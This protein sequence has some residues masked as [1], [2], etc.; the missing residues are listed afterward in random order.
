MARKLVVHGDLRWSFWLRATLMAGAC[1]LAVLTLGVPEALARGV[2]D[3]TTPAAYTD[4]SGLGITP[5][6]DVAQTF[7]AGRTGF[8]D[9]VA[10]ALSGGDDGRY[11]IQ[12]VP[13]DASGVPAGAPLASRTI[14]ACHIPQTSP[15]EIPFG[16]A[17]SITAGTRYA[18]VAA[19]EPGSISPTNP[20]PPGISWVG[21]S[22]YANGAA[23]SGLLS[24]TP[25]WATTEFGDVGFSTYVSTTAP[26]ALDRDGTQTTVTSATNPAAPGAV[27]FTASVSDPSHPARVPTG[28]VAFRIDNHDFPVIQPLDAQ[29][30]ASQTIDS[31]PTGTSTITAAY[32]PDTDGFGS[33]S[34]AVDE[35]IVQDSTQTNVVAEPQAIRVGETTTL[36]AT[37]KDS[38]APGKTPTGTVQFSDD[39]NQPIGGPV[40]LQSGSA[41]V[42]TPALSAGTHGFSATYSASDTSFVPSSGSVQVPVNH[43]PSATAVSVQ[44]PQLVAGQPATFDAAVNGTSS[45]GHHP[46]GDVQFVIGSTPIGPRRSLDGAGHASLVAAGP[47]GSYQLHANYG[48]DNYFAAGEGAVPLTVG[49]A[50]TTTTMTSTPNPVGI[51]GE[52]TIDVDVGVVPPGD[53]GLDGPLQFFVDGQPDGPPIDLTGFTGVTVTADAGDI[54]GDATITARYLG[55]GNT[56][57]S[58]A[59][60]VQ[61]VRGAAAQASGGGGSGSPTSGPGS[62]SAPTTGPNATEVGAALAAVSNALRKAV[63]ARGLRA[64][65]GLTETFAAPAAGRLVQQV[66]SPTAPKGATQARAA[67]KLLA[68]G[69]A[70]FA[71]A[72][73]GK[74]KLKLTAAGR[75]A[76]RRNDTIKL[77]VV[78][79]FIPA[80][81]P[82]TQRQDHFS[83]R[84]ATRPRRTAA[85]LVIPRW[86]WRPAAWAW[87]APNPPRS[88]S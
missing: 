51:R 43:W 69:Q 58:S 8:L 52:F 12:V 35:R 76:L 57:P 36:T 40:A 6:Y 78:T 81:G 34:G 77:A 67:S 63:G 24:P 38:D 61:T 20:N 30:R 9:T 11:T 53:V 3:Q 2:L 13:T 15:F 48:G 79:R 44:P 41:T 68:T 83:A 4:G 87:Q 18:I 5:F 10:L 73:A 62:S 55:G 37:V 17:A 82:A 33:S 45:D 28:T 16:P 54:A 21:G 29:G 27:T 88:S 19:Y 39:S 86:A 31:L 49:R 25:M 71:A 66:Y 84:R 32:C 70:S 26:P 80:V 85:K 75:R 46:A 42:T 7:T 59:A 1:A 74:V 23:F 60:L 65:N 56:N 72:G 22:P 14:D 64:L 47:A 50:D